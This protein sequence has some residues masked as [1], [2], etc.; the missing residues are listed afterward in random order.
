MH[1]LSPLSPAPPLPSPTL[2]SLPSPPLPPLPL[3]PQGH[4]IRSINCLQL[5]RRAERIACFLTDKLKA[6]SGDHVA[7]IYPPGIDLVAAFYACLY[8]GELP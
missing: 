6:N 3:L 8:V 2:P 1:A 5:H 4:N 7:L